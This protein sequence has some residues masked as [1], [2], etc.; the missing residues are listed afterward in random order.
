MS[1][2]SPRVPEC[3]PKTQIDQT[4]LLFYNILFIGNTF[5]I[6]HVDCTYISFTFH[7]VAE[8]DFNC[9]LINGH[10]N[11]KVLPLQMTQPSVS[12]TMELQFCETAPLVDLQQTLLLTSQEVSLHNF[13][14]S[15]NRTNSVFVHPKPQASDSSLDWFR[16][17]RMIPFPSQWLV[18]WLM[19]VHPVQFCSVGNNRKWLVVLEKN[20]AHRDILQV[21]HAECCFCLQ[22]PENLV[23]EPGKEAEKGR[24][25]DR[26]NSELQSTMEP[27]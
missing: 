16:S 22:P 8:S 21:H 1:V 17:T 10:L 14:A 24:S 3:T 20:K 9:S 23:R 5:F 7:W 13:F 26:M 18:G 25:R 19:P 12:V 4:S 15:A 2:L 11:Y 6:V 27:T